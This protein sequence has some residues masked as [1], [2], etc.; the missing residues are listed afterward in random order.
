MLVRR[1][2]VGDVMIVNQRMG[3]SAILSASH[4]YIDDQ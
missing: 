4:R 3:G 1:I 2:G